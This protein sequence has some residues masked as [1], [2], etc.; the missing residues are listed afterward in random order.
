MASGAMSVFVD[1]WSTA[2]R[3]KSQIVR[4][5]GGILST[6]EKDVLSDF[7][8]LGSDPC[9]TFAIRLPVAE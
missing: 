9:M 3:G 2:S 6:H 8:A 7:S 5:R 4:Y 1:L